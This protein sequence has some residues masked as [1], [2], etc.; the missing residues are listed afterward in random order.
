MNVVH[1]AEAALR[2]WSLRSLGLAF[3]ASWVARREHAMLP[4]MRTS[5]FFA[6]ALM[7]GACSAESAPDNAAGSI[8]QA[9]TQPDIKIQPEG[10]TPVNDGTTETDEARKKKKK[11][12]CP[13]AGVAIHKCDDPDRQMWC[14]CPNGDSY[15][16]GCKINTEPEEPIEKLPM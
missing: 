8:K 9:P 12:A 13:P 14:P 2:A 15:P 3:P 4:A 7:V 5:V 6:I 16:C 1:G 10:I 11:N